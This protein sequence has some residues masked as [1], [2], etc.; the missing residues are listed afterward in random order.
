MSTQRISKSCAIFFALN[1]AVRVFAADPPPPVLDSVKVSGSTK[2]LRFDPYPGAQAYTF[3]S[4][5]N[6][7]GPL[8]LNT[9]FFQAP[10]ITGYTLITNL[11]SNGPV[12]LTVTNFAYEWR[13]TNV[14][15]ASGFYRVGV[16]PLSNNAV[17]V[18]T[19]LNRLAY[20]P[21]PDELERVTAIGP[22]AYI[23]EQVNMDGVPETLDNYTIEPTNTSVLDPTTNWN[24]IT[25]TGT[26]A[27][28]TFYLFGT[29]A[30]ADAYLDDIDLR[31][32][33]Y[34]QQVATNVVN[35]T[36]VTV[37]NRVFAYISATNVLMNGDFE[38]G[39]ASWTNAGGA[40]GSTTD[41]T[42]AHSGSSCL[43][44]V[45]STGASSPGSSYTRQGFPNSYATTNNLGNVVTNTYAT[46][47]SV[48][49]TYWY[50]PGATSSKVRLQLG[51]GIN[52]TPGALA[53]AP[54]WVYATATG[55]ANANSRIYVYLSGAGDGYVDDM[56]LVAGTNAGAGPNLLA[57]G[58]FEAP[59]S[60][61]WSNTTD[62]TN[63]ALSAVIAHS[64]N[65]SLHVVATAAGS[66]NNDSVQQTISP[67]LVNG[68]T[69]TVSYWYLPAS[70][71]RTLTVRLD[72][73]VLSS[74]PDV[75]TS[76]LNRK[77][78]FAQA[79]LSD[80]RAWFCMHAVNSPRQLFEVLSQ[81]WENHFV[82][83][84]SKSSDYLV[85]QGYDSTTAGILAT[86]WEY[87][88]M[89]KWRNA[90]LNPNCTFYDLLKIHAESPAE[91]VYLD[92]VI[93]KGNGNNIANE[94][95]GRELLELFAMGVDNGYDQNDIVLMSRAWTGWSVELVDAPNAG[96]PFAATSLTYF[97]GTNS[98]SKANTL[99]TWAFNFKSANH[100]TN[101]GAIFGGKTVPARFGP[102]WAG[103]PYQIALPARGAVTN[104]IQDGYDVITNL[105]NL[106]FTSEN[107]CVKLCRLFVHDDF[108]NPTTKITEP[109][110]AFYDYTDPNRSAE[111]ELVHQCM[112]T[113]ENSTPKGNLRAVL[114]TIFNSDLFRSHTAAAQKVKTPLEFVASSVRALRSSTTNGTPTAVTDGY[115]FATPLNNMGTMLLFDRAAPDGYSEAAGPWISSGTLVERIRHIQ[116]FCNSGT[117][118]DAGSHTCDPVGLL[119]KKI[120]ASVKNAGAVADYFLGIL[121]PGEGK[122]NLAL[123][124]ATA[125]NYLDTDDNGASSPF[126]NLTFST[127]AGSTYDNR[128]RGVVSMLMAFQRFQEQ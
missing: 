21:T 75:G 101:R 80:Y 64:G 109:E 92:S 122:A 97:P 106:P 124:R 56:V 29:A 112:L 86:D 48:I 117:G 41:G 61:T 28:A 51:S 13:L 36:N 84:Q 115:S 4:G 70:Q 58:N 107:L 81:F 98:T 34:F 26:M 100:G 76:A 103:M 87:R 11:T 72:G 67:A 24:S 77:L 31:P 57:N 89:T 74:T 66:G 127:T 53:P 18:G 42:R 94:N 108:P 20:G 37:T 114:N 59:L 85:G 49:L 69:Y 52:S 1:I 35:G 128:V 38:S 123:Y 71:S 27:Q 125:V 90:M 102:P 22:D 43:H 14:T 6:A 120:P 110:Y 95:Y 83:Q 50:Q 78:N 9:N 12:L 32:Y 2:G 46:S 82:T 126:V 121:Y 44:F 60:G 55:T 5:T 25:L 119:L 30:G 118:D 93:S 16:T 68:Q 54:N 62:F 45:S 105:A 91:I 19:V 7:S 96:D 79:T 33:R 73:R 99:G 3:Y 17:L 47:D 15:A 63:S 104:G 111:A 23:A 8:S 10:Y 40:A 39:Y 88:E 65:S 113:W 116:A